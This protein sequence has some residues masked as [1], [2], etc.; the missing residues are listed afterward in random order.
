MNRFMAFLHKDAPSGGNILET[1]Y[2]PWAPIKI[3]TV[4][5]NRTE[6]R[7]IQWRLA[8][9][10]SNSTTHKYFKRKCK[11]IRKKLNFSRF[12]TL[13]DFERRNLELQVYVKKMKDKTIELEWKKM[14]KDGV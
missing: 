11:K 14:F 3:L 9:V 12:S 4:R 13:Y 1:I 2:P 5:L 10:A 8:S 6:H 7:E